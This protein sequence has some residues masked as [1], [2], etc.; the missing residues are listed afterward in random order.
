MA[1][2]GEQLVI[3]LWDSLIDKGVGSLLKPWQIRREGQAMI[4][5]R[6]AEM[7]QMAQVEL[8]ALAIKRGEKALLPSGEIVDVESRSDNQL[9]IGFISNKSIQTIK[10]EEIRKEVSVNKAIS[11]AEQELLQDAQEP[12]EKSI[13]GDW[14]LRWREGAS[15]VSSEELTSLWG[16]VLAGESKGPGTYSLRTLDF[17]KHLSKD[18]ASLIESLMA[19]VFEGFIYKG[20]EQILS[21]NNITFDK[22]LNLQELGLLSGVDSFGLEKN[23]KSSSKDAFTLAIVSNERLILVTNPDPKR[24]LKIQPVCLLTT[25]GLQLYH[26][27]KISP[28]IGM[29]SAIAE[30]IKSQGFTAQIGDIVEITGSQIKYKNLTAV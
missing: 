4:D 12:S 25:I 15:S 26:L 11:Y 22:L 1:L 27:I 23:W 5:V 16:K 30:K 24:V 9:T 7:L 10:A 8:D 3:K 2:L 17:L 13:D 19:F 20:D 18:E 14:L 29:V 28:N 6:K 21:A